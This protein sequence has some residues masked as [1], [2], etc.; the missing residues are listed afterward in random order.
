MGPI[1][2]LAELFPDAE[3]LQKA[4]EATERNYQKLIKQICESQGRAGRGETRVNSAH[5]EDTVEILALI[6]N[7]AGASRGQVYLIG[8]SE[9]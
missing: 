8:S 7:T 3:G 5:F 9:R 6:R 1:L 2:Q 4:A